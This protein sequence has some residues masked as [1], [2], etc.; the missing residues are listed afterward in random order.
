[1]AQAA[2]VSQDR[3]AVPSCRLDTLSVTFRAQ[4]LDRYDEILNLGFQLNS[5]VDESRPLRFAGKGRHFSHVFM[6]GGLVA[7]EGTPPLL[8]DGSPNEARNA[9]V[10][11]LT[12]NGQFFTACDAGERAGLL[13]QIS[14]QPG[15]YHCTRLDGQ[16]TLVEPEVSAEQVVRDVEAGR[17]WAARFQSQRCF[18]DRNRDGLFLNGCTQYWGGKGSDLTARTYD[19]AA[20]AGWNQPAVRHELQLRGTRANDRFIQLKG[21]LKRQQQSPP[22]LL[23]AESDF[24]KAML[25]QDLDYRDTSKWAGRRK[26]KNW[27]QSAPTPGWWR[28]ATDGAT[29]SFEYSKRPKSDLD[30]TYEAW[31]DQYGRKWVLKLL[32]DSINTGE[33]LQDRAMDAL[34]KALGRTREGDAAL[35]HQELAGVELGAVQERLGQLQAAAARYAE[36]GS[37]FRGDGAGWPFDEE[38]TAPHG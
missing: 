24:V 13:L 22:L 33:G 14:S 27:A 34:L 9:G 30:Q 20:Q 32:K 16:I 35:V 36:T 6:G 2:A 4:T 38:Q 37:V 10:V 15:F 25:S 23:T 12:L 19:K 21:A 17:L 31:L 1:M 11:S 26:P 29:D 28:E 3:Q 18:G 5:Y 7:L 8:P